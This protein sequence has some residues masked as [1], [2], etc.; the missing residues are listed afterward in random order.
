MFFYALTQ[1]DKHCTSEPVYCFRVILLTT[2]YIDVL[3]LINFSLDY[4]VIFLCGK[5]FHLKM[6]RARNILSAF[7]MSIY[8]VWALLFCGSYAILIIS[9][10]M[11]LLLSCA[12]TYHIKR[13]RLLLKVA[14]IF[15]GISALLG[16]VVNLLYRFISS[17]IPPV[18]GGNG[19]GMK[20]VVFTI[21]AGISGICIYF[22][23]RLL[24]S[25]KGIREVTANIEIGG[26]SLDVHLLVDSGNLL[27]DPISGRRVI[28]L[29]K[30]SSKRLFGTHANE[31][32]YLSARRRWICVHGVAGRKA[33]QAFLPEKITYNLKEIDALIAIGDENEY[34][35]Y[36]GIFPAALL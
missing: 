21:L 35:G 12:I 36:E 15:G 32:S 20:V 34:H 11:V 27:I 19:G 6:R 24:T 3:F 28:I 14:F 9:S 1:T 23:N 29:S 26:V 13:I 16:A 17:I 5:L 2:V 25:E 10:M 18:I 8:A 31:L 4:M 30:N 22:G 33:L 7:L